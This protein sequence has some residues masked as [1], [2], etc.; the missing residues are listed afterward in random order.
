LK[1]SVADDAAA[2]YEMLRPSL[3]DPAD[4]SGATRG[5]T[6]LLRQGM[7]AWANASKPVPA[8]SVSP[9]PGGGPP[10]PSEV[11]RELVQVMA[12]LILSKGKDCPYA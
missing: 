7:L 6:V 8:S 9:S 11:W 12:G 10:V 4:Q 1:F 5:R 3:I 2:A